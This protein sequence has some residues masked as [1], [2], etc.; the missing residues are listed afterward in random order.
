MKRLAANQKRGP[1]GRRGVRVRRGGGDE[2]REKSFRCYARQRANWTS[3]LF[4]CRLSFPHLR[5]RHHRPGL[6]TAPCRRVAV[7]FW[8]LFERTAFFRLLYFDNDMRHIMLNTI[9]KWFRNSC[10]RVS[11]RSLLQLTVCVCTRVLAFMFVLGAYEEIKI[12]DAFQCQVVFHCLILIWC[13]H[14]LT[15]RRSRSTAPNDDDFHS[16]AHWASINCCGRWQFAWNSN[17]NRNAGPRDL[18]RM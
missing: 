3:F 6:P 16:C 7:Y 8:V 5:R 15:V 9:T 2:G 1:N 17:V 14:K 10:F 18:R 12:L 11:T 4:H 13:K